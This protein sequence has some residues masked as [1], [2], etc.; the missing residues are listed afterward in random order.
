[1]QRQT[2]VI[3]CIYIH[4][5]ICIIIYVYTYIYIYIS[6]YTDIPEM[7]AHTYKKS[8]YAGSK[9]SCPEI[10][11]FVSLVT[12]ATV[13]LGSTGIGLRRRGL[14]QVLCLHI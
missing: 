10:P 8:F 2:N 5:Y 14:A 13:C 6:V 1:M 4:I 3:I 9:I 11:E 7:S 12:S